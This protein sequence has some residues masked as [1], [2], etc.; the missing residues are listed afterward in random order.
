MHE[1]AYA[2]H[3]ARERRKFVRGP[4]PEL[5]AFFPSRSEVSPGQNKGLNQV[6]KRRRR[7][8]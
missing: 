6:Q 4:K 5:E 3:K 7:R 8:R 1:F 2:N